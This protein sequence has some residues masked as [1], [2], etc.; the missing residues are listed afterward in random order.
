MIGNESSISLTETATR[1]MAT[2]QRLF[3]HGRRQFGDSVLCVL[4]LF[5]G[6]IPALLLDDWY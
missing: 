6:G 3:Q 5:H 1:L 4:I 2:K